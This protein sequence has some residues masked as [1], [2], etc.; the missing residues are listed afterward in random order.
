VSALLCVVN[1]YILPSANVA[2]SIIANLI[3]SSHVRS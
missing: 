3:G 2:A 1:S